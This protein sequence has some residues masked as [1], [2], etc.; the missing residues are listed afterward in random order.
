MGFLRFL[1]KEKPRL[2]G[3]ELDVPPIPPPTEEGED[4]GLTSIGEDIPPPPL[5]EDMLPPFPGPV[6]EERKPFEDFIPKEESVLVTEEAPITGEAVKPPVVFSDEK[7]VIKPIF[8]RAEKFKGVLGEIGGIKTDLKKS[9]NAV[10]S[11]NSLE[12]SK[13]KELVK[14]QNVLNDVEKKLMLIDKTLFKGD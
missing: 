8:V 10:A 14:W 3:S 4:L 11:I 9:E 12:G 2:T 7:I 13:E 6:E 5:D 1:K